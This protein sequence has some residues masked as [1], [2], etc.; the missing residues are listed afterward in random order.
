MSTIKFPFGAGPNNPANVGTVNALTGLSV[1]E[2]GN[3]TSHKTVLTLASVA[4][5]SPTGAAALG[6]GKL[7][8][9]LPAGACNILISKLNV[10]LACGGTVTAD[11]PK[12]GMGTVVA[13]GVVSVLSGTATFQN[14]LTGQTISDVNGT[15][16]VKTLKA[17]SSPFE[18]IVE[19][20]DVHTIYLNLANTW[21][22]ADAVTATGTIT[23][24]YDFIG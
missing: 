16:T 14:I 15:A 3:E 7:M 6:F 21:A 4:I 12:I 10:S 22:G 11:T 18:L 8:Y 9:T 5:G 17:T 24:E 2:Y 13:S 23:I 1:A 19:T 20:A